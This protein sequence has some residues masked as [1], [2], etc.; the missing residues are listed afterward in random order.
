VSQRRLPAEIYW[1]RRLLLLAL[2]LLVAWLGVHF[3]PDGSDERPVSA[4]APTTAPSPT[5]KPAPTDGTTT[6][7][8]SSG[9]QACDPEAIRINPSVPADQTT[10]DVVDIELTISSTSK[11]A[12][13]FTAKSSDLLVVI[14]A[15]KTAIWDSTVCKT[16]LLTEAV[17]L[18]PGWSTVVP[19]E[20]SGRGSGPACSK[21]EGWAT[22]GRYKIQ[23]G[24]LGGEP[25]KTTFTLDPAPKPEKDDESDE[26]SDEKKVDEEKKADEKSD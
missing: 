13:T 10:R 26:E 18:S 2:L 17:K 19:V 14:S 11:K 5:P 15:G 3:W 7:A 4:S 20:W 12:C 6:V 1:R 22:P 23:I 16:S 25:G 8:L 9:T 24:T 21:K